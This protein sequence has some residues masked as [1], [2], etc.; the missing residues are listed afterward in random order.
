MLSEPEYIDDDFT[1]AIEA[2]NV[3]RRL[4][5]QGR[6][7]QHIVLNVLREHAEE[8]DPKRNLGGIPAPLL[9]E[10]INKRKEIRNGRKT[11]ADD[12][13]SCSEAT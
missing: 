9:L 8:T 10:L 6:A 4:N 1:D 11:T 7:R 2:V 3:N 13:G 5:G 12:A